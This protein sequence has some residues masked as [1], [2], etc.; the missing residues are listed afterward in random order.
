MRLRTWLVAV[1]VPAA[2]AAQTP[3][4]VPLVLRLPASTRVLALGN[5]GVAGRDDDVIFYNPAQLTTIRGWS[6]SGQRYAPGNTSGAL[7]T[8]MAFAGGGLGVGVQ[9]LGLS[10][11]ALATPLSASS[12]DSTGSRTA[13]SAAATVGF[14]R[15]MFG[16]RLGVATKVAQESAPATRSTNGYFD[17]GVLK[18][19]RQGLGVGLA[20]Q[21]IP[22]FGV[23]GFEETRLTLGL[24]G[25]TPMIFVAPVSPF[26][27]MGLAGQVSVTRDGWVKPSGGAELGVT[28]IQGYFITLRAGGRR[29]EPGEKPFTAGASLNVDRVRFD[30]ALETRAGSELAHRVGV[31]VR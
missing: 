14:G 30:Y 24:M 15:A 11:E 27:D 13:S 26:I 2:A 3:T 16:M 18:E 7:S 9:W 19:F 22:G 4:T 12:L 17:L 1:A 20:I 6:L 8:I 21:N 5:S 10:T 29:P 25:E 23:R 31:R 28:W